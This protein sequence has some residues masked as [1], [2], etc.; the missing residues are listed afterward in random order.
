MVRR[1][2]LR[3]WMVLLL[4]VLVLADV[5]LV[6]VTTTILVAI[7]AGTRETIATGDSVQ[8]HPNV[9]DLVST[10][11]DGLTS[12]WLV[13][14]VLV[15]G[16]QVWYLLR[17]FG[18]SQLRTDATEDASLTARVRRLA[19]QADVASPDVRVVESGVA[20]SF[21]VGRAGS[22]TVYAT[23][24]LLDRLSDDELDAVLAHELA[25]VKNRDVT[26]TTLSTN[27]VF[28]SVIVLTFAGWGFLGGL[29]L[30]LG[31]YVV[32]QLLSVVALVIP[33]SLFA[34]IPG[35]RFVVIGVFVVVVAIFVIAAVS[36]LLGATLL[37]LFFLLN[38]VA[39]RFG[40][41]REYAADEAAVEIVGSPAPLA[42]A[43]QRLS[44][45]RGPPDEDLRDAWDRVLPFCLVA[46]PEITDEQPDDDGDDEA[47]LSVWPFDGTHPPVEDRIERIRAL[48]A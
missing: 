39:R 28:V 2:L 40:W 41:T 48:A 1:F 6:V 33:P 31:L 47:E 46:P 20:N 36:F 7:S 37:P 18:G 19:Q 45:P 5:V 23:S 38:P 24:A 3:F 22:A 14:V 30:M 13:V 17:R 4:L 25:H 27:A 21:T 44:D 12:P 16:V 11:F 42:S 32:R 10:V 8:W 29:A 35:A 34:G 43:L 15:F 9:A 26:V